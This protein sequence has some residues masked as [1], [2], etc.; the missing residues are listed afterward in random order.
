MMSSL[1]LGDDRGDDHALLLALGLVRLASGDDHALLLALGLVRL[2]SVLALLDDVTQR[3]GLD[4]VDDLAIRRGI[5]T[6][7]IIDGIGRHRG[8]GRRRFGLAAFSQGVVEPATA[9]YITTDDE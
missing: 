5:P 1:L 4:G 3:R 6:I 7:R 9:I 8:A 2:A